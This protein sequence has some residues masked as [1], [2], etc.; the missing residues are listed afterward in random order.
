MA[1]E[2]SEGP[3]QA[4]IFATLS[5]DPTL[6]AL[7]NGVG[8]GPPESAGGDF[9]EADLPYVDLGDVLSMQDN[10]HGVF[11]R[12]IVH[13]IH[14][15]TRAHSTLPGYTI[16]ARVAEL[17]DHQQR[18]L[19]ETIEAPHRVVSIRLEYVQALRDPRPDIRHHVMRFRIHA[20]V[21]A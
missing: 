16:A 19:N 1:Q 9:A 12:E 11:G 7:I 2:L 10:A 15:W 18:A 4:V 13:T 21:D 17:L 8:D 3:V 6:S 14:V 20:T 5:T